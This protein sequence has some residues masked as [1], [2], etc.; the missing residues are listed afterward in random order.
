MTILLSQNFQKV[1]PFVAE[2]SEVFV[3]FEW[4]NL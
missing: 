3:I 2:A 1:V 4:I